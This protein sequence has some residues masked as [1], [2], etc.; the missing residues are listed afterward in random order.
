MRVKLTKDW[1]RFS[2]GKELVG[3][4]AR[5]ALADKAGT[6]M[7]ATPKATKTEE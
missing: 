3:A 1:R 7:K 5:E 6:E 4:Q 2:K